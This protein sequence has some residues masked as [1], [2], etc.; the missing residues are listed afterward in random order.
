MGCGVEGVVEGDVV[1]ITRCYA[2]WSLGLYQQPSRPFRALLV[3]AGRA[4]HAQ[5]TPVA[6]RGAL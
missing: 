2:F 3:L 1:L 5:T 6:I 4:Q